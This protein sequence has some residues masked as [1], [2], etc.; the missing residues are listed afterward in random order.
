M[1]GTWAAAGET[2]PSERRGRERAA[3]RLQEPPPG[4]VRV[5]DVRP[6][7]RCYSIQADALHPGRRAADVPFQ[8]N[9]GPAFDSSMIRGTVRMWPTLAA[10]LT[11]TLKPAALAFSQKAMSSPFGGLGRERVLERVDHRLADQ[12]EA[13]ADGV[14]VDDGVLRVGHDRRVVAVRH[15]LVHAR[16]RRRLAALEV[17][18]RDDVARR[19]PHRLE[20][21]RRER[22]V[23]VEAE[24]RLGL[25]LARLVPDHVA[26]D[27]DVHQPDAHVVDLAGAE[28]AGQV[29]HQPHHRVEEQAGRVVAVVG[30]G[31]QQLGRHAGWGS[32][33]RRP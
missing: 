27:V 15:A 1:S 20:R 14:D 16:R 28:L 22:H 4:I 8:P 30:D 24:Q 23:V 6:W 25:P 18:A 33:R 31:D 10:V 2:A 19:V 21:L 11:L 3:G 13:E 32:V 26:G 9:S 12:H 17:E 7:C 29:R 5:V